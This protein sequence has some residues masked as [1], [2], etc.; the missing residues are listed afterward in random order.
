VVGEVIEQHG[1]LDILVNTAG[2]TVDRPARTMTV[3][4]RHKVLRVNLSGAFYMSQPAIAHMLERG[5]GLII[6]ISSV[7]GETGNIGR[8]R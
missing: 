2:V 8:P 7:V 1:R 4:D 6:N 5:S 3:D